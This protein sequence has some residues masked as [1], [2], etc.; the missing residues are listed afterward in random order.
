MTDDEHK[1]LLADL[2]DPDK[3]W[4][5]AEKAAHLEA[6]T[7]ERL[8]RL[9]QDRDDARAERDTALESLDQ[10]EVTHQQVIAAGEEL[11]KAKARIVEVSTDRNVALKNLDRLKEDL[12]CWLNE[13]DLEREERIRGG[14]DRP[15][16]CQ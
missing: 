14:R 9:Y 3:G 1:A 7:P 8:E 15:I 4:T 5:A 16:G 6:C 11:R 10:S 2:L 13:S 12:M